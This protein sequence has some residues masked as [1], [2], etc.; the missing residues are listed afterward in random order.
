[1]IFKWGDLTTSQSLHTCPGRVR[2]PGSSLSRFSLVQWW[3]RTWREFALL[4]AEKYFRWI[5][6][7]FS[8]SI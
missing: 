4:Y 3:S 6:R 8:N 2:M 5:T 7:L 1:L